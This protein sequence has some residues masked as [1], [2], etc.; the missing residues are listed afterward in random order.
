MADPA[1]RSMGPTVLLGLA[2][3]GVVAVAGN[4]PWAKASTS[5][6]D[7]ALTSAAAGVAGAVSNAEA[8]LATSIALVVLAAWGVVLVIRG[9]ARRVM[10]WL[11]ALAAAGLLLTAVV[12]WAAAPDA[13]TEAYQRSGA[14]VDVARTWWCWVAVVAAMVSLAAAVLAARQVAHWPE[15]GRRYDAPATDS[16]SGTDG[17]L[18]QEDLADRSNLELW[19]DLDEGRDPTG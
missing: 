17:G 3:A 8:P 2:S 7:D 19:K 11:L 14:S 16:D 1:R 4:Q 18:D 13:V 9:R 5:A 15:M 6:D 12:T 10:T